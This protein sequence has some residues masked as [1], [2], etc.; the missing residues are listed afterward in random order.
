MH[1]KW[2]GFFFL[3]LFCV[4]NVF[5]I[6]ARWAILGCVACDLWIDMYV[7]WHSGH[8]KK[9]NQNTLL[10]IHIMYLIVFFSL[11]FF[12][13][14]LHLGSDDI[15][16]RNKFKVTSILSSS[17]DYDWQ[18]IASCWSVLLLDIPDPAVIF[19]FHSFF[20]RNLHC[21]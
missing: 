5:V 14:P 8:Q 18:N 15:K 9:L 13:Y 19:I 20:I 4:C 16:S 12:A 11:L 10:H 6:Y 17:L 3:R 21:A 7:L 2:N 1:F